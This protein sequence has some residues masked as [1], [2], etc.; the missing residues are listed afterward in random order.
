MVTKQ[1]SIDRMFKKVL[2]FCPSQFCPNCSTDILKGVVVSEK[3][4]VI[5]ACP[6]CNESFVE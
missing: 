1:E 3:T 5:T 2:K 6:H 4:A